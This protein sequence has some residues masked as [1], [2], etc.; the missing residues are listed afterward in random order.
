M[1]EDAGL[2]LQLLEVDVVLREEEERY[3]ARER[4]AATGGAADP[5]EGLK[6]DDLPREVSHG[7]R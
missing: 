2:L 1:A 5:F 3:L 4:A 7:S 6:L